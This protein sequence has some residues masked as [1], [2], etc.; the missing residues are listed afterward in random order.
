MDSRQD[1]SFETILNATSDAVIVI[2][3][4]G[5]VSYWNRAAQLLFGY[6]ASEILGKPLHN[7]LAPEHHRKA[8]QTAF[9]SL[10]GSEGRIIGKCIEIAALT[11]SDKEI[12]VELTIDTFQQQGQWF[13]IATVRDDKDRHQQSARSQLQAISLQL[14]VKLARESAKWSTPQTLYSACLNTLLA[15]GLPGLSACGAIIASSVF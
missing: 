9:N 4:Q 10:S 6:S 14:E 11:K 15:S 5:L 3:Q 1:S 2:D 8:F 7:F 13:A 12:F